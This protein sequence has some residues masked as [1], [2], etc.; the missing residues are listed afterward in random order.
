MDGYRE[1]CVCEPSLGATLDVNQ[2]VAWGRDRVS[3]IVDGEATGAPEE[4]RAS[5]KSAEAWQADR[6]AADSACEQV[7]AI[8]R[9]K[10]GSY[11]V[12]GVVR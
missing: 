10:G 6:A 4:D 2:C 7:R 1:Q 12:A 3:D 8:V 11:G 9:R 5:R